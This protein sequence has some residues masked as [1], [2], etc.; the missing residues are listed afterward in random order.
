MKY[1][2]HENPVPPGKEDKKTKHARVYYNSKVDL[3]KLCELISARSSIS[4]ADVKAVL[5]SFQ[6]WMAVYL[7]DGC[8]VELDGLGH[9]YPKLKSKCFTEEN[10]IQRIAIKVDT[11]GFRC[12]PR[13]KEKV[14][15][16]KLEEEKLTPRPKLTSSERMERICNYANENQFVDT[17]KVMDFNGCTRHTALNDL[18]VLITDGKLQKIKSGKTSIYF[19]TP[20]EVDE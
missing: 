20:L 3:E 4:S 5:D 18:N 7:K 9:F 1:V 13:L 6:F 10:G 16:A 19:P 2:L 15:K 11:V 14:R 12:S 17:G 8:M